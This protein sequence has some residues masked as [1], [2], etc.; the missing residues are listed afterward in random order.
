MNN[1][2][3]SFLYMG[4]ISI[5]WTYAILHIVNVLTV[6][7]PLTLTFLRFL[8]AYFSLAIYHRVYKINEKIDK[9]DNI[10]LI[11]NGLLGSII[12]YSFS[13]MTN[14]HLSAIDSATLSGIQ[15][16]LIL[17]VESMFLGT[18]VTPRKA[19]YVVLATT[20]CILLMRGVVIS[21]ITLKSYMFMFTATCIWVA[22]SIIQLPLLKKYKSTTI[23]KYQSVYSCLSTIP[24]IFIEDNKFHLLDSSHIISLFFLGF[25]GMALAY[26]FY[27]YSLKNIGPVKTS[28]LLLLQ[29]VFI[30]FTEFIK[31]GRSL[32]LSDSIG[33]C[34][35]FIGM[36][37]MI[38]DLNK[39]TYNKNE[40]EGEIL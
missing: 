32:T 5:I 15:L 26:S 39:S 13:N 24:F 22:Y 31:E 10:R 29:P 4:M 12:Y 17:W 18:I 34:F 38:A 7:G 19:F 14:V 21:L 16:I 6:L 11:T 27:S 23:I 1:I 30:L 28:L 35:I 36:L 37:L 2:K 25:F 3:K 8:V 40:I 20:G 33:L 9:K